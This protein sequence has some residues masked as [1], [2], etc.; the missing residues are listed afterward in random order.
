MDGSLQ[1]RA[2]NVA[3][4][5]GHLCERSCALWEF[6]C[7]RESERER[8]K[9]SAF[10]LQR[11]ARH[12][13]RE[14]N[15]CTQRARARDAHCDIIRHHKR[16]SRFSFSTAAVPPPFPPL[17]SL[18]HLARCNPA[19][20]VSGARSNAKRHFRSCSSVWHRVYIYT[21]LHSNTYSNTCRKR[22]M[23]PDTRF[24]GV[25]LFVGNEEMLSF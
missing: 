17:L 3:F 4:D 13:K 24:Y 6:H 8:W 1:S 23:S 2:L 5:S 7:R 19:R 25:S 9:G 10:P 22:A 11:R 20:D 21:Q 14:R 12:I 15:S 18:A 16:P